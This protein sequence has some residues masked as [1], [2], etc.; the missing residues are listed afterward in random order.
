VITASVTL[1]PV[2]AGDQRFLLCLYAS[3]REAELA[4]VPWTQEQKSVFVRHQF[5]AQDASYRQRYPDGRFSV[6]ERDGSSIGR[7]YLGAL[8]GELR[9]IDVALVPEERGRG[10]GTQLV[11]QVIEEADRDGL[12][13]SL[14]VER[15]NPARQLYGRLG[16]AVVAEDAVYLRMER[17]A[18]AGRQLNTAS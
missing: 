18:A 2:A 4:V 6:V 16:F 5:G 15:W 13:V 14:H 12:A 9:I 3:V 8:P 17:P 10:I 11:T 7:L 1:R